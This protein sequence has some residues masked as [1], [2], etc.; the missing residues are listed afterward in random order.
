[1]KEDDLSLLIMLQTFLFCFFLF[2]R[3]EKIPLKQNLSLVYFKIS[4][5]PNDCQPKGKNRWMHSTEKKQEK[6]KKYYLSHCI[7]SSIYLCIDYEK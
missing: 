3:K 2:E 5:C 6:K 4:Q 7:H 1:M